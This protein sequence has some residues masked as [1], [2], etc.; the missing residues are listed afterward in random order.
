MY[1][2]TWKHSQ[3]LQNNKKIFNIILYRLENKA[4]FYRESKKGK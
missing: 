3:P 4:N 1:H 2:L